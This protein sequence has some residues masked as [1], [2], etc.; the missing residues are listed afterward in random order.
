MFDERV[1]ANLD[2]LDYL[3][4][5]GNTVKVAELIGLSQSSCS[6]RCRALNELLDL[7]MD[8]SDGGYQPSQNTD[9]LAEMRQAAQKLRVR[10]SQLR[11]SLESQVTGVALPS[12]FRLLDIESI[13]TAKVLSLL[14]GRLVDVWIGGLQKCCPMLTPSLELMQSKCFPLGKFLLALPLL[15]WEYVLVSL[16]THPLQRSSS[17]TPDDL[18]KYPSL[19]LPFSK[20]SLLITALQ[21][22]GLTGLAYGDANFSPEHWQ[23]IATRIGIV[24]AYQLPDIE[25]QFGLVPLRYSLGIHEVT[26][27]V[28][29]RDVISDP[30][31]A[32]TS[33]AL[34]NSMHDSTIGRCSRTVW[35]R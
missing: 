33:D 20:A 15:R 28:G 32:K 5:Y 17:I 7:G 25:K 23:G 10:R 34:C 1:L 22:H 14:E 27:L 12:E 4:I 35:L 3:Q 24:P 13:A 18:A 16:R 29:H 19:I 11:C 31:F 30:C 2:A 9:V 6:R 8:R 26:A 21:E